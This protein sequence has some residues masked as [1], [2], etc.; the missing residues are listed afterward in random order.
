MDIFLLAGRRKQQFSVPRFGFCNGVITW[1]CS[2]HISASSLVASLLP[3]DR[4]LG[5]GP[6]RIGQYKCAPRP[7]YLQAEIGL[8]GHHSRNSDLLAALLA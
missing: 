5:Q 7:Y 6:R 3:D 8:P 4:Y 1:R 2:P